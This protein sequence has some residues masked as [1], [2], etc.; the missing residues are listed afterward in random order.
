MSSS[1][2]LQPP[3]LG[4]QLKLSRGHTE[5]GPRTGE[6]IGGALRSWRAQLYAVLRAVTGSLARERAH[7]PQA[8]GPLAEEAGS[9][10]GGAAEP[11][12]SG[13]DPQT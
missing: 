11:G 1:V 6:V 8:R 13:A 7:H 2:V 4:L 3:V 5:L 9:E 10:E 12:G